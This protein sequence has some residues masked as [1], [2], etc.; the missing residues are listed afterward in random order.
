[1]GAQK[2]VNPINQ[3][4]Y[5][6]ILLVYVDKCHINI[7]E[8]AYKLKC[9]DVRRLIH[10]TGSRDNAKSTGNIII[11]KMNFDKC[12]DDNLEIIHVFS[13]PMLKTLIAMSTNSL[14]ING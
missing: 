12:L 5:V 8:K 13:L 6:V 3:V 10:K 11:I 4:V 9:R 1:V 7:K 14:K 2:E